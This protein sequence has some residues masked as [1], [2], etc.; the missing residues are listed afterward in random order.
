MWVCCVHLYGFRRMNLGYMP[1]KFRLGACGTDSGI[2]GPCYG[3][4]RTD[5]GIFRFVV[6]GHRFMT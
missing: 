3:V 6:W 2:L 4:K 1:R 5:F